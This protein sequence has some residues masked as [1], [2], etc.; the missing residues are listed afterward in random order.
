MNTRHK[1][2]DVILKPAFFEAE[3]RATVLRY[4]DPEFI[5]RFRQ[6]IQTG[7]FSQVQF[8]AWLDEE[9]H[10]QHDDTP[11]LRLPTHRAFHLVCCEVA[12]NQLG[13]PALDPQ[14]IASAGFV[15][16]REYRTS[17][18]TSE[19]T[20]SASRNPFSRFTAAAEDTQGKTTERVP[21]GLHQE[22]WILEDGEATGW[23]S[24]RTPDADPDISRRLC[25]NGVLHRTSEQTAF[26]GE[27]VYPLH[28]LTVKD[29]SGKCHTLL[30]GYVP[31]GGFYYQRG[32]TLDP[33]HAA[34]IDELAVA[35]LSWPFGFRNGKTTGWQTS[36]SLQ[37]NR[38]RPGVAFAEL[39][40]QLVNRYHLG[41]TGLPDN[42]SLEDSCN[43]L[44]F[45]DPDLWLTSWN[46]APLYTD[47]SASAWSQSA[48]SSSVPPGY[49]DLTAAL[50]LGQYLRDC[51][52]RG[53]D[54]PLVS[55]A[56]TVSELA[57]D[58]DGIDNLGSIP[59]LPQADGNGT[60]GVSL[61]VTESQAETLRLRLGQ[62]LRSLTLATAREFPVPKFSQNQAD[63]YRILPFVR[64]LTAQGKE[65]IT[66]AGRDAQSDLF[67]V[68]ATF[69]PEASRPS[70]IPMPSLR[71]LKRGMAKGANMVTP[72]DTFALM[73]ALKLKKGVTK[74]TVDIS[75]DI[76]AGVQ[77][78]CS[79]SLPVITLVAMILLM[80]MVSLLNIIFFWMPWV[81]ICLPFPKMPK[82]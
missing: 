15:V 6:D 20:T 18:T 52:A 80:I 56:A 39:L 51:F 37:V 75:D 8:G 31:L 68:A 3:K 82:G 12:C 11:V 26:S 44:T 46:M 72:G 71:D 17:A 5:N 61:S 14:K 9:R 62:R 13:Q 25:H 69:D 47:W 67:R 54:N 64:S 59:P 50:T 29:A 35:A 19:K 4:L 65:Q 60:L 76:A 55:W 42:L 27:E 74:D 58:A 49:A 32:Q 70:L 24:R 28:P 33:G 66:W 38:G 53:S 81:R 23:H 36:D 10:S 22:A 63:T 1:L 41:E 34:E 7:R 45:Y 30:F 79:F 57:D 48:A 43:A 21:A 40:T 16:R 78:I 2:H 77:W 73:N